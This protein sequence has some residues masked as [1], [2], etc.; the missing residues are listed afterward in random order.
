[1][2]NYFRSPQDRNNPEEQRINNIEED[3]HHTYVLPGSY[4]WRQTEN[5]EA[6]PTPPNISPAHIWA[7][8]RENPSQDIP[9]IVEHDSSEPL[10]PN[11]HS[12]DYA[13]HYRSDQHVHYEGHDHQHQSEP[14]THNIGRT[15]LPDLHL[16][17]PAPQQYAPKMGSTLFRYKTEQI[18]PL[19]E[20]DSAVVGDPNEFNSEGYSLR[21]SEAGRETE[22]FVVVTMYNEDQDLF[23]KTWNS[24]QK[25]INYLCQK[26]NAGT[27]GPDGWQ[28]IV[29]CVVADGRTK[30]NS[31]TLAVIGL[32]G[33]YQEGL[34]KTKIDD[35]DVSAHLFEYTTNVS[36]DLNYNI[37]KGNTSN[38][39]IQVIFCLK[40]KNAKKI[41][42]HRWFFNAF[43][44][45]LNPKVCILI[46]VG[47]KPTEKSFYYLWKEFDT[48]PNVAGACGEIYAENG[49]FG[50]KL[51]NPLVAA[52][53]FEYK[54][55]NILDKPMES[56]FGFISVLPGAFSAYRY[57]ALQN[58]ADGQG[59]L[60]KYFI[61]EKMHGGA[62]LIMANMHAKAETDVPDAVPEYVSQRRRWSIFQIHLA[63]T[64][65]IAQSQVVQP[66]GT[67]TTSFPTLGKLI[68]ESE[69]FRV[70]VLSVLSTV[71][72]YI[73]SSV[74]FLDPWHIIT[75][76]VQYLM[77]VPSFVNI[78]MV[79]AFCNLHDVSWGTKGDNQPVEIAQV[80]VQ[81]NASGVQVATVTLPADQYDID[82]TYSLFFKELGRAPEKSDR[83]EQSQEDYFKNFRTRVVLI[84]VFSNILLVAAMITPETAIFFGI[85]L[86]DSSKFN[87]FLTFYLWSVAAMGF[88]RLIGCIA[89]KVGRTHKK[90]IV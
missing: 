14:H 54:M 42:S 84:W 56:V 9:V 17:Y 79:Y 34:I 15:N 29:I 77:L 4:P 12:P 70:L 67:A 30:I 72:V 87:P 83:A 18:I 44:A 50:V 46:D 20:F 59:P 28:K 2:Q 63:I 41:N 37:K 21:Q 19:T 80:K 27:W 16:S 24:L 40:E 22:I 52:Q 82:E 69:S 71:G 76:F 5:I 6:Q 75:S 89:Y 73:V 11:A 25:N 57:S 31:K 26:R 81:K 10:S 32:L 51:L 85:D 3:H 8:P 1:M 68:A 64:N 60:E 36:L 48:H 62:N 43:G 90:K 65:V 86:N 39:P 33:I 47:T 38:S 49:P 55:S 13:N 88:Y 7:R 61:G 45:M 78:L 23:L 35:R 66:D 53:N 74:L 58:G